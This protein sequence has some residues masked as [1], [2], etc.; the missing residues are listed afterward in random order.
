LTSKKPGET[1]I[2]FATDIHGSE[3]TFRKF[4]NGTKFYRA[5]VLVLGGD[6][7]GK[8]IVP[9]V[10]QSDG[11]WKSMFVGQEHR[12]KTTSE[13]DQLERAIKTTGSYVARMS[14]AQ[15]ETLQADAKK[16]DELFRSLMKET[17]LSWMALAEERLKETN[18]TCYVTGGND[19]FQEII[20]AIKDTEHVRNP[21][22]KVVYIDDVHE[23]ASIGW[24]NSTPWKTPRECN[25]EE[26]TGRI[27]SLVNSVKEFANTIFNFHVPPFNSELD[28]CVKLDESVYPPKPVLIGG[29][30]VSFP[31]GSKAIRNAI[32][33][34]QPL[35]G[36][37]GHIHE[38]R[39]A[40]KIGRTLCI[41]PGSEYEEAL[42][43]G[44]IV[45]L[46]DKK[47]LSHQFVTG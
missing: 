2:V 18:V 16:Q 27:E 15:Y 47:V 8:K 46:R 35:L 9:V 44:V 5:D 1:R 34:Y 28:T 24:G 11:T 3:S 40:T 13:L 7:T 31:A 29:Q 10:Q 19:D 14:Q 38:P 20:D 36:L 6:I 39:A 32:E 26:L 37:H 45:N 23:M 43:R 41:N 33:R 30:V 25:E 21:D 42:L 22:G 4:L 17:V 12:V